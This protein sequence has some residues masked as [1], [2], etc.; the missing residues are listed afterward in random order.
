[1]LTEAIIS[2]L[3]SLANGMMNANAQ[4]VAN[5]KNMEL[6][7]YAARVNYYMW[8]ANNAYNH[9]LNQMERLKQAGLNPNLVYGNGAVGNTSSQPSAYSAPHMSPVN[10]GQGLS[11]LGSAMSLGSTMDVQRSQ[12]Y[13]QQ[14]SADAQKQSTLESAAR[15][16]EH[17]MSA[18]RSKFDYDLAVEMRDYSMQAMK[19][20]I[21][22]T[23][24]ETERNGLLNEISR[25]ELELYPLKQKL[26][27]EQIS[28]ISVAYARAAWELQQEKEGRFYGPDFWS[29]MGNQVARYLRGESSILDLLLKG[30]GNSSSIIHNF[31]NG[32]IELSKKPKHG[33]SGV[34]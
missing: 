1:M 31:L 11:G 30:D 7:N 22:K 24:S 28:Q 29:Q 13:L 8:A 26:T 3:G 25:A 10:Y 20:N 32:R 5:A 4:S 17:W 21:N 2:G 19:E 34:R 15:T 33:G 16:A 18:A 23:I 12:S 6:A 27:E 9:P 14:T